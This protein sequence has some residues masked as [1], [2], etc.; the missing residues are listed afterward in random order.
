M[1][2]RRGHSVEAVTDGLKACEAVMT[3]PFDIVL[4]DMQMPV[5]DGP[6]ATR[7]IRKL[8]G[9]RGS[10]PIIALTADVIADHRKIYL[11]AGV[12]AVVGKPVNWVELEH[13]IGRQLT[14]GAALGEKIQLPEPASA[15]RGGELVDDAALAA[16]GDALGNDI[17]ATMLASCAANIS[18]YAHDL[19]VAVAAGDFEKSQ[20][21]AHA[22]KGLCAQF[23]A[24]RVAALARF[25][26]NHLRSLDEILPLMPEI[27]ETVAA[28]TVAFTA[29]RLA[30]IS[31]PSAK[32][33]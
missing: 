22:L 31:P 5:M 25:V 4:M 14:G 33:G 16:L 11:Q 2:R 18:Q 6:E 1:L 8:S 29:R 17:L 21:A 19:H 28:T 20:R 12:N 27:E 7:E 32:A 15:P 13:E 10:I 9:P 26:E 3:G 24:P 30:L 23:G